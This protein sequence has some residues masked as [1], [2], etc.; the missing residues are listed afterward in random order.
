MK[1]SPAWKVK[2]ELLAVQDQIKAWI[3]QLF[4]PFLKIY[5][6]RRE[7]TTIKIYEGRKELYGKLVLYLV[8]QPL[9]LAKS[10][11]V[12]IE[13]L[14]SQ[15]YEVLVVSNGLLLTEDIEKLKLLT[16]RIIERG[17]IGYDF[18]GYRCGLNYLKKEG[19]DLNFLTLINDSIWF[20]LVDDS[21][22]LV[23]TE[24]IISDFG[25]AVC[26]DSLDSRRGG[27]VLSYWI[28][29]RKSLLESAEFWHFWM[30]YIPSGNKTLT[31]RLGERGLSR[32]M[33]LAGRDIDG[34]FTVDRFLHA[35]R[36]ANFAQ[37]KLTLKYGSFTDPEF[38]QECSELL[39]AA[40]DTESWRNSCLDFFERVVR[41]R[42]FLHSFCYASIAI[43][44][45]PF[46]KKNNL[47]LQMLMREKYLCAVRAGDLPSPNSD[48][49]KEIERSV[50]GSSYS[51]AFR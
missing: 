12:A 50:D 15:G 5:Y 30:H 7:L 2:R 19:V 1:L 49:L 27:L 45:V 10:A 34:V 44:R 32:R 38:T 26:L 48:V 33:Q 25:G 18:G 4:S 47:R 35:M 28:T 13:Y 29:L 23:Q 46:I 9:G 17:N 20:P 11:Y 8:F 31:V 39:D 6:D 42:N 43:L 21:D 36:Y 24:R 51:V 41:R 16:W 22:I 3:L 40:N 14:V 37:L